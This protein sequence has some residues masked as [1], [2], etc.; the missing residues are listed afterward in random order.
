MIHEGIKLGDKH[1]RVSHPMIC[2]DALGYRIYITR[3][4]VQGRVRGWS[5]GIET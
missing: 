4:E 2:M 1:T 5:Q 3:K